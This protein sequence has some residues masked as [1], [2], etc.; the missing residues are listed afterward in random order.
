MKIESFNPKFT[1]ALFGEEEHI[2]G[3]KGLK[4]NLSYNASDLRPNLSV[5]S[6]RKFKTIGDVEAVDVEEVMKEFLPQGSHPPDP[7]V[8]EP[9]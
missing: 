9:C 1:Y 6:V 4:V 5:A 8:L 3:Y 2:F 7:M